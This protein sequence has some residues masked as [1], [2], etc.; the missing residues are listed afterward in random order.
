MKSLIFIYFLLLANNTIA[1]VV[2]FPSCEDLKVTEMI[3]NDS[4]R[5]SLYITVFNDCDTCDTHIYTGLIVKAIED[6][7]AID[8][9]MTSERTPENNSYRTYTL[10]V[11]KNFE[12]VDTFK[13]EM[14]LICDSVK[15]ADG[16]SVGGIPEN[17]IEHKTFTFRKNNLT[18]LD[19]DTYIENVEIYNLNGT[20]IKQ[21]NKVMDRNYNIKIPGKGLFIIR[22]QLSNNQRINMKYV[23][24]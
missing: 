23:Q 5:D 9:L 13:I 16:F 22:A 20:L 8:E 3:F 7:L 12:L 14:Y 6:T 18:L 10:N 15:F 1:Q 4:G 24:N 19:A 2:Y 11:L 17:T 21:E